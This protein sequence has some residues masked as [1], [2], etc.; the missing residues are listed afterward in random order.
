MAKSAKK[1]S[2]DPINVKVVR[3]KLKITDV[4][5]AVA[6]LADCGHVQI[7]V[8]DTSR[9]IRAHF[10]A[11]GTM[12][13]NGE[14]SIFAIQEYLNDQLEKGFAEA[15]ISSPVVKKRQGLCKKS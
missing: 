6:R 4:Q 7:D 2:P 10:V 9:V 11:L 12:L 5:T 3:K 15:S 8:A 1:S 13:W 14:T